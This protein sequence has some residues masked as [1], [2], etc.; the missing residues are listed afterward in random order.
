[1]SCTA[2]STPNAS[3]MSL[4]YRY[5][6]FKFGTHSRCSCAYACHELRRRRRAPDTR[7]MLRIFFPCKCKCEIRWHIRSKLSPRAAVSAQHSATSASVIR[8]P[9]E[10]GADMTTGNRQVLSPRVGCILIGVEGSL[11]TEPHCSRYAQGG[12]LLAEGDCE[13]MEVEGAA[14]AAVV[15]PDVP[16]AVPR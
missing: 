11:Q 13:Q 8:R 3:S 6:T 15:L 5:R 12:L 9:P 7:T 14:E 4:S 10:G 16:E 1:M 2:T